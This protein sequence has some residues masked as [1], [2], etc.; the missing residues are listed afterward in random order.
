[1]VRCARSFASLLIAVAAA[2]RASAQTRPTTT[3]PSNMEL[4]LFA[5]RW[6]LDPGGDVGLGGRI[7]ATRTSWLSGEVSVERRP[8]D[9]TAPTNWMA[10]VDASV[11]RRSGRSATPFATVGTALGG[12][13]PGAVSPVFGLGVQRCEDPRCLIGWRGEIQQFAAAPSHTWSRGRLLV[14]LFVRIP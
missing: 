14:T 12:G 9:S 5:G 8:A 6:N 1:M 10:I 3:P 4:G 11:G 7:T 2:G 13:L